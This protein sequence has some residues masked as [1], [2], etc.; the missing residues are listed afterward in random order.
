MKINRYKIEIGNTERILSVGIKKHTVNFCSDKSSNT[1]SIIQ[2]AYCILDVPD[3]GKFNIE[4]ENKILTGRLNKNSTI[5]V[6]LPVK[7]VNSSVINELMNQYTKN[8]IKNVISKF[9]D[10]KILLEH[11]NN[12]VYDKWNFDN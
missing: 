10:V 1:I 11:N 5:D 8:I 3:T 6:H 9:A 7:F 12:I 4:R 2:F